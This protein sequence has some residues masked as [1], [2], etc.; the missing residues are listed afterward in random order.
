MNTFH[1]F[2]TE[3]LYKNQLNPKFWNKQLEFDQD[4][5]K[6]LLEICE[7][8]TDDLDLTDNIQDIILTGSLANY[9]YTRFSDLDVHILLDFTI[10]NQNTELVKSSLDGKRFVWNLRHDIMLR[11]HEV[12]LY[13][14]DINEPHIASGMFSILNDEWIKKPVYDPP[15]IDM[16]YVKRKANQ[17]IIDINTLNDKLKQNNKQDFDILHK[18][19][20]RLREKIM[21]MR[22]DSLKRYGEY[23]IGNLA[24]KHLRNTGYIEKIIDISN[25][26]YDEYFSEN[27]K[28]F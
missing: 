15:E 6:K 4:I 9:N 28:Y 14:Q 27:H 2:L 10:I 12:E 1:Q 3:K 16:D 22:K 23:G 8:F 18:R 26:A 25:R 17:F 20:S 11:G 7:D 24:F 19:A 5:R 21:K 13:F